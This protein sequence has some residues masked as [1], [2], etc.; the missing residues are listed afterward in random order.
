MSTKKGIGDGGFLLIFGALVLLLIVA[1]SVLAP[2]SSKDDSRPTTTN[3]GPKGAK[4]A[5]L[6]LE[7]IGRAPVRWTK[8][9]DSLDDVDASN[10]TLILAAP[11][12][13][14]TDTKLLAAPVQR[15]LERGGRVLTTGL[16]GA[17]L[18]PDGKAKTPGLV[19]RGECVTTPEGPGPLAQAGPVKIM[20][21]AGWASDDPR[22]VVEQRCGK[23]TVVVRYAVGKGE[24][25]WWSSAL[26]LTNDGLKEDG[27]L[28]L[29]LASVGE[30]RTV[31]FDESVH[32]ET[33]GLWGR[34]QGL[35]LKWVTVQTMLV[36]LLLVLSFSRRRGP[37]RAPVMKPRSSP[38]EFAES[39]GDLYGKAGATSAATEAAHRRL[40]RVL[41]REAGVPLATVRLG[42][43]SVAEALRMRLGDD[44]STLASHLHDSERA[45]QSNISPRSALRLVQAMSEDAERVRMKLRP[46]ANRVVV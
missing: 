45:N 14:P 21:Y 23:D 35:P 41:T 10:S 32:V 11:Q 34:A 7:Q 37:V 46:E 12:L 38:V 36:A 15:F 6:L 33:G 3:N 30:G 31:L 40:A 2:A 8:S 20:D 9:L 22:Y 24:A 26:P 29:L 5:F 44:W 18:L 39:M 43:D 17:D 42:P 1:V 13:D 28:R 4:A 27:N 19:P 25:I 16:T